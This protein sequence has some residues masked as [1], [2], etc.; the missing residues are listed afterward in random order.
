MPR[1]IA[2]ITPNE[3]PIVTKITAAPRATE[4]VTAMRSTINWVTGWSLMND[5]PKQGA[6]HSL[7]MPP[8]WMSRPTKM[9]L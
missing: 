1:L 4:M 6:G 8:D 7:T 3:Q 5:Q 2:A 9:P